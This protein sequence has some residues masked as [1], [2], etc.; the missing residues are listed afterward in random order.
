MMDDDMDD[1]DSD[2]DLDVDSSGEVI[3]AM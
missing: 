1:F 3:Y 2:P